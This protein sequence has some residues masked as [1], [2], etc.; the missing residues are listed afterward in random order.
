MITQNRI[1][2][3]VPTKFPATMNRTKN[4]RPIAEKPHNPGQRKMKS[5]NTRSLKQ[6]DLLALLDLCRRS[7]PL[8]L[9]S[10]TLLRRN[11]FDGPDFDP[12]L[13]LIAE[14]DNRLVGVIAGRQITIDDQKAGWLKL[15]AVDPDHQNQTIGTTLLNQW[16]N[17]VRQKNAQRIITLAAPGYFWPGVDVRYTPAM[18]ILE[19]RGYAADRW[20]VNMQV[21]L[22]HH[23]DTDSAPREAERRSAG[24]DFV[25]LSPGTLDK[26]LTFIR[27]H[28]SETWAHECRQALDNTPASAFIALHAE[29]VVGFAVYDAVM[30]AGCFGPMGTDPAER[31][32]GIGQILLEKCLRDMKEKGYP[33][34]EIVWIGPMGFYSKAANATVYRLFRNY[35]KEIA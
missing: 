11:L 32:K 15:W 2:H 25:R 29:R 34:C 35:A 1:Q 18:C 20:I 31:G 6:K 24:Y 5:P 13:N 3:V 16:E 7:L 23:S 12:D 19:S 22:N 26:T 21:D 10:K 28:F 14:I 4:D 17:A 27:T 30:F 33:R 9:F 8:D